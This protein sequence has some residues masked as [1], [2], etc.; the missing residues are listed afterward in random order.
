M[1][2]KS[3]LSFCSF[4]GGKLGYDCDDWQETCMRAME[5]GEL[6]ASALDICDR[7]FGYVI[8]A[9]GT[10]R[11]FLRRWLLCMPDLPLMCDSIMLMWTRR[12][13]ARPPRHFGP[14]TWWKSLRDVVMAEPW[15][16]DWDWDLNKRSQQG[17]PE[18]VFWWIVEGTANFTQSLDDVETKEE[19]EKFRT[20]C[21]YRVRWSP[22]KRAFLATVARM[23]GKRLSS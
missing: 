3:V 21:T 19:Y 11:V 5:I 15:D 8:M 16:W 10:E 22:E 4:G 20:C 7:C 1:Q 9:M 13:Y 23:N 2:T 17:I 6:S 14:T 12:K 18:N